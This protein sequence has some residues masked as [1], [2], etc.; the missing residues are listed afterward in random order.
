MCQI[1]K[2]SK[3]KLYKLRLFDINNLK[4]IHVHILAKG[5]KRSRCYGFKWDRTRDHNREIK[6]QKINICMTDLEANQ[7]AMHTDYNN[8]TTRGVKEQEG[9]KTPGTKHIQKCFSSFNATY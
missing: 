4:S 9:L 7:A 5:E 2:K 3:H 8:V 1:T 6:P